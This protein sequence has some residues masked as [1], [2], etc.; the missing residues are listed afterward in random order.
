MQWDVV[1]LES[2]TVGTVDLADGV[3]GLDARPDIL[4][5]AVTWQLAKRRAGT[6]NT[7]TRGEVARTGKK[8]YRQKGTGRARQ[9]STK[10]PHMRGGGIVFGPR[11]RDHAIDLPKKVRK[12]ALR[13]ALSAK[14]AAG[15]LVVLDKA[16]LGAAK[17]RLL[18]SQLTKLGWSKPLVIDA[19]KPE[20]NFARAARNLVGIDVLPSIGANV[21][22]ILRHE[23]LVLTRSA[24]EKLTERLA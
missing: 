14:R 9:G 3:F 10:G 13:T 12:L 17:T 22:D 8:P 18:A 7:K 5:R 24:V 11:P 21:Y 6:H 1:N 20:T 2:E 19:E 23:T 4:A 15:E 16:E